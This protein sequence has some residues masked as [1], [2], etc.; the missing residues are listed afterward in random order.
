MLKSCYRCDAARTLAVLACFGAALVWAVPAAMAQQAAPSQTGSLPAAQ[1]A[2]NGASAKP[3]NAPLYSEFKGIRLGM[4]ASEIR[5]KLGRPE[6]KSDA[7]DFFVFSDKE[8]ARVYYDNDHKA[9]AII[10]TYVGKTSN[11]PAPKA[12]IGT[13]IEAKPD[14]SMYSIVQYPQAGYWVAYSRTAGGDPLTII[15]MQKIPGGG[16]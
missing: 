13:D 7:M 15:T 1:G 5:H 16:K 6:E 9:S 10:A 4:S 2:P 8:R 12:V 11:V 14:G 3:S